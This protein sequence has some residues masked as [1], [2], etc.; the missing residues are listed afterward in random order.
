MS[1]KTNGLDD[2]TNTL[3][4]QHGISESIRI[5]RNQ[6]EYGKLNETRKNM[7]TC[8]YSRLKILRDLTY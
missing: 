5:A 3:V 7:W 8:V 1:K 4:K 2:L 6:L